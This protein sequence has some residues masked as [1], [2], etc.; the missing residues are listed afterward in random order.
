M[1]NILKLIERELNKRLGKHN[2]ASIDAAIKATQSAIANNKY[3]PLDVLVCREP[4]DPIWSTFDCIQ[5][6][7]PGLTLRE[8]IL[9]K[10]TENKWITS[11][12]EDEQIL[13]QVCCNIFGVP[14]RTKIQIGE[15]ER[16][17]EAFRLSPFLHNGLLDILTDNNQ[18]LEDVIRFLT[19]NYSTKQ[20]PT[21]QT[22]L[23]ELDIR[24]PLTLTEVEELCNTTI[25]LFD[26]EYRGSDFCYVDVDYTVQ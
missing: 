23:R 13:A 10:N 12:E 3:N 19:E 2:K 1:N 7:I 4:S 20:Y 18:T 17:N 21:A 11:L 25:T 15:Y 6:L 26:S 8:L 9:I 16:Y 24:K 22:F 5:P 14:P